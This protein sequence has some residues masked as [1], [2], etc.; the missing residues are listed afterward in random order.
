M[1]RPTFKFQLKLYYCTFIRDD[2]VKVLLVPFKRNGRG[3][4]LDNKYCMG[5]INQ[6]QGGGGDCRGQELE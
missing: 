3:R 6:K 1:R 5:F 2:E 4:G